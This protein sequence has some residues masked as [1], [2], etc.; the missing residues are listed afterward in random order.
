MFWLK[1]Y[2]HMGVPEIS[3]GLRMSRNIG[4]MCRAMRRCS[5]VEEFWIDVMCDGRGPRCVTVSMYRVYEAVS[6]IAAPVRIIVKADQ[7]KSAITMVSSAI[8][9]VVGGRAMFVRLA[10]SHQMA[11]RGSMGCSPRV[12]RRIRL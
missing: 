10:R 1:L 8:R 11:I 7:L 12:S 2:L 4:I 3:S 6:R 5:R 9:F